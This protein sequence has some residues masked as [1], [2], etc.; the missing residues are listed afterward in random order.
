MAIAFD[1]RRMIYH[2]AHANIYQRC[3]FMLNYFGFVEAMHDAV[4]NIDF[5]LLN[6]FKQSI[7]SINL[8]NHVMCYKC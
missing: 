5:T 4:Y 2:L 7:L 6:T 3:H 1:F 8:S